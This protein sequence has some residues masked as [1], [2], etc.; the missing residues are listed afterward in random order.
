MKVMM[1]I[2]C[3][4]PEKW[5]SLFSENK[6][7]RFWDMPQK[8]APPENPK[9]FFPKT[10]YPVF[11]TC[12]KNGAKMAPKWPQNGQNG[13]AWS[14]FRKIGFA[15]RQTINGVVFFAPKKFR[16]LPSAASSLHKSISSISFLD[17]FFVHFLKIFSSLE[18]C[19]IRLFS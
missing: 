4:Y 2:K 3:G 19:K 10:R 16:K 17:I 7:P 6:I 11:G 13:H 5:P 12:L 14:H 1:A 15:F 8:W 18:H 9:S